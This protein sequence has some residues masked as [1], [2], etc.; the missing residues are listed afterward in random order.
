ML[1]FYTFILI[2]Y[3]CVTNTA[4]GYTLEKMVCLGFV[5]HPDSIKGQPRLIENAWLLDRKAEWSINVAGTMVRFAE[6]VTV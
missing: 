4:Y 1:L 3:R 6:N 2:A 5:H